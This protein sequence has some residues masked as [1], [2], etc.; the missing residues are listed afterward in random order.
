MRDFLK[1]ADGI[2]VRPLL[3]ELQRQP[4]LWNQHTLRTTREG[5]AHSAVDDIWIRYNDIAECEDLSKFN[6]EH[7][8]VWYPAYY[9]LPSIR[10]IVFGLMSLVEGERLGGVLI[11]RIPPGGKIL[12]HADH[13]WHVEHY[14]KYYV[15]LK[16]PVGCR[17][18]SPDEFIEPKPGEC[19]LF[20][21]RKVHWVENNS[22]DDRITLIVCIRSDRHGH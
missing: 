8:S 13:G 1:V 7:E 22:D 14:D 5:T 17:F 10:P 12:P 3:I 16:N 15:T 4:H 19:W 18:Y 21:N 2:E 20:D 6:D 11:T 9:A